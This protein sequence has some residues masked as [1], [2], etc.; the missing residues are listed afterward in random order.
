MGADITWN[1]DD[2]N[3]AE[4]AG[5]II[6]TEGAQLRGIDLRDGGDD[7]GIPISE[8]IDELP[9]LAL[10]A[11]IA[12]GTTI[13]GGAGELRVKES[14]RISA[15]LTLLGALGLRSTEK[16]DGFELTGPQTI[17]GNGTIDHHGDHRLCMLAAIAA[18]AAREPVTIP[19]PEVAAVS[20]P[21]FWRE[22]ERL[23][24][25]EKVEGE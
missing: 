7:I 22:I 11:T 9:L 12:E 23:T 1:V 18:L 5:T 13:V 19:E 24:E 14:D 4:P 16:E 6:V 25:V 15:T 2:E 17:A 20:W 10:V 3:A 21:G 8:M